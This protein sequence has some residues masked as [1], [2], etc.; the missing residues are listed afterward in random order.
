MGKLSGVVI[1]ICLFISAF[2]TYYPF[3]LLKFIRVF[4]FIF[5]LLVKIISAS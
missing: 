1:N 2:S 5:L 4:I 3:V